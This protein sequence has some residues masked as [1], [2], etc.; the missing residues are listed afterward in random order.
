MALATNTQARI[1]PRVLEDR[2]RVCR[3]CPARQVCRSKALRRIDPGEP[4][5]VDAA[6]CYGC[7][8]CVPA[9]PWQAIVLP[10]SVGGSD[11]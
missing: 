1:V 9:C 2:C 11:V 7:H 5:V 6:L 8:Q 3:K 4:P 10:R